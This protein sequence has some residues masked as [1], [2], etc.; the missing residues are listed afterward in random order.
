MAITNV[1]IYLP[2]LQSQKIKDV[3]TRI[4]PVHRG[5]FEDKVAT[6]WCVLNMVY[7]LKNKFDTNILIKLAFFFTLIGCSIPIYVIYKIKKLN[8]KICSQCFGLF[9]KFT[10]YET[11]PSFIYINRNV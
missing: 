7:K 9:N 5:I 8:K 4:F 3:F 2:W 11:N 1:V 6:F 10:K